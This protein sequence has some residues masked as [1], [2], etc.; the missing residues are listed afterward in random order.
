[1]MLR[2]MLPSILRPR[3]AARAYQAIGNCKPPVNPSPASFLKVYT[4][5]EYEGIVL[6]ARI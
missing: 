2:R 6:V 1:M 5:D 3:V 4:S